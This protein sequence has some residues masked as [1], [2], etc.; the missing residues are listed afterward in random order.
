MGEAK[1][2]PLARSVGEFFGILADAVKTDVTAPKATVVRETIEEA[3]V[4]TPTG[5][6]TL[7]RRVIDEVEPARE[8]ASGGQTPDAGNTHSA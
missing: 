6:L 5:P 7:R 3:R 1:R 4:E 8:K 2:K